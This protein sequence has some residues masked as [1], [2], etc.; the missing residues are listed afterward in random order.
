MKTSFS[1][2]C[3]L[4]LLA[5]SRKFCS[6]FMLSIKR[7]RSQ[8]RRPGWRT[9]I[10]TLALTEVRGS[11]TWCC[12]RWGRTEEANWQI[13]NVG[14]LCSLQSSEV[15]FC[16]VEVEIR[17]DSADYF[18]LNIFFSF[19]CSPSPSVSQSISQSSPP[20]VQIQGIRALTGKGRVEVHF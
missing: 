3:F 17:A 1:P 2:C 14:C 16:C 19:F 9:V 12:S 5:G 11:M 4:D 8:G 6:G 13:Q 20:A 7:K 15:H 18:N 10:L